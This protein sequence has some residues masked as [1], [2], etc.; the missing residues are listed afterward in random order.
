M[1]K[2]IRLRK[3]SP[4]YRSQSPRQEGD[5]GGRQDVEHSEM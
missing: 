1:Q 2:E 4:A 5:A 3:H